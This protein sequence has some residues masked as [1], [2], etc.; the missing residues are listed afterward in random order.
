MWD[1]FTIQYT[2][3]ARTTSTTHMKTVQQVWEQLQE[4]G[5]IY[6]GTYS[7]WYCRDDETFVP[8]SKIY[9]NSHGTYCTQ[10]TQRPVEK[11]DESTFFFKITALRQRLED[12]LNSAE[13]NIVPASYRTTMLSSLADMEDVSISRPSSRVGWGIPVPNSP[14]DTI[15]VWFDAL[16]V[17]FNTHFVESGGRT[18]VW[19]PTLQI[20]GKDIVRFHCLL[21]PAI[22]LALQV[23]LP[24]NIHIHGHWLVDNVKMSKSL[25]N[26]LDPALLV[27][28]LRHVDTVRYALVAFGHSKFTDM[29]FN[30]HCVVH[31]LNSDLANNLGNLLMR[32]TSSALLPIPRCVE[33]PYGGVFTH[34]FYYF[35]I[36]YHTTNCMDT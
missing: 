18:G 11:L 9:Q 16:C 31:R 22:L 35:I 2:T 28:H 19:P 1:A 6:R 25:N 4:R 20:L 34:N 3:Y 33:L 24:T 32:L 29:S 36:I 7:G 8:Q 10:E 5:Y 14:T 30:P 15:Y 21:W 12:W 26:V 27:R 23:P 17:Y 13:T